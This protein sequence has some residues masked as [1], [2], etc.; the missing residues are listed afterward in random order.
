MPQCFT[1]ELSSL[2][3]Q[4]YLLKYFLIAEKKRGFFLR[5]TGVGRR[6]HRG[7]TSSVPGL[8]VTRAKWQ[9]FVIAD[10]WA[11]TKKTPFNLAL[12][13]L[14]KY[15]LSARGLTILEM[16]VLIFAGAEFQSLPLRAAPYYISRKQL[17]NM[18]LP[19]QRQRLQPSPGISSSS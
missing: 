12:T 9:I 5:F 13:M 3:Y 11:G 8:L 16:W 10:A 15:C 7:R 18:S 2:S 1:S 14:P 6:R 17:T 19:H 4:L